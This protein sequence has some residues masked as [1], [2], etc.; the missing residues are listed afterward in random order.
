MDEDK[1][2]DALDRLSV[3]PPSVAADDAS[4]EQ[5]DLIERRGV[6][7]ADQIAARQG[8][9]IKSGYV[10][11]SRKAAAAIVTALRESGDISDDTM[12]ARIQDYA[13]K[14]IVLDEWVGGEQTVTPFAGTQV[15]EALEQIAEATETTK[16]TAW[17]V[18]VTAAFPAFVSDSTDFGG[19]VFNLGANTKL[20]S[21][22]DQAILAAMTNLLLD[23]PFEQLVAIG[24]QHSRDRARMLELIG[25][26]VRYGRLDRVKLDA[27][28]IRS[29]LDAPATSS[30]AKLA[31]DLG[32]NNVSETQL[33]DFA[34]L[35]AYVPEKLALRIIRRLREAAHAE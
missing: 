16:M 33:A 12:L 8:V 31:K 13:S 5:S 10:N 23:V 3:P 1:I 17:R 15:A 18:A 29:N 24:K 28:R 21:L 26:P 20:L 11:A 25:L 30:E 4:T 27:A 19:I 34:M 2:M 7:T 32:Q 14:L 35:S 6:M 9:L 22:S